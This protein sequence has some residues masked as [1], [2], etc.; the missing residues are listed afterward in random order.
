[1][2]VRMTVDESAT[3]DVPASAVWAL[4]GRPGDVDEWLPAV[5]QSRMDGDIRAVELVGGGTVHER[6]TAHDDEKRSY[7][8]DYLDGPLPLKEFSSRFSVG[9]TTEQSSEITWTAEFSADS[10]E[11]GTPLAAAVSEMYRDGLTK[12][13]SL[14]AAGKSVD[15]VSRPTSEATS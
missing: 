12:I 15:P 13:E 4:T 3:Y 2:S 5:E 11:E 7:D 1:M 10:D 14:L 6:I 8:Y 9:A